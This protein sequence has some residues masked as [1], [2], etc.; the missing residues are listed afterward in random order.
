MAR[1]SYQGIINR[2]VFKM[3]E[4]A[5]LSKINI[6]KII[7]FKE[8]SFCEYF[9]GTINREENVF[10]RAFQSHSNCNID[11]AKIILNALGL[12]TVLNKY[13]HN[14][15]LTGSHSIINLVDVACYK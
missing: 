2:A 10:L 13:K 15:H 14:K 7:S 3:F 9:F 6:K 12:S 5:S 4:T 11:E 8:N 1:N